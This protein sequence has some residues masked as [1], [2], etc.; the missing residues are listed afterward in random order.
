MDHLPLG[1][2]VSVTHSPTLTKL[3]SVLARCLLSA[4][5][6]TEPGP[7]LTPYLCSHDSLGS[8]LFSNVISPQRPFLATLL[9]ITPHQYLHNFLP[10]LL[11]FF[12]TGMSGDHRQGKWVLFCTVP[13]ATGIVLT[14]VYN[15]V[16]ICWIELSCSGCWLHWRLRRPYW[17]WKAMREGQGAEVFS[18]YDPSRWLTSR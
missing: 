3:P 12:F 13:T 18:A 5:A 4:L 10:S 9:I 17:W 1:L 11:P 15:S 8:N 7:S 2:L 14:H 16:N 6:V